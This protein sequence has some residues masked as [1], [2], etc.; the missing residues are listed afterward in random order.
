MNEDVTRVHPAM[1]SSTR[2]SGAPMI[3]SM[4]HHHL[5]ASGTETTFG[6]ISPWP[7]VLH[8]IRARAPPCGR[9]DPVKNAKVCCGRHHK[10]KVHLD[11]YVRVSLDVRISVG[12][13]SAS[14]TILKH[15][16]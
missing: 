15:I 12:L 9:P 2:T 1:S 5:E 14:P 8:P 3:F 13:R 16:N 4:V 7:G 10:V 6:V 11:P